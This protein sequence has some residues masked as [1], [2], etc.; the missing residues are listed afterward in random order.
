MVQLHITDDITQG[1][2]GQAL[3][4]ENGTLHAVGIQL[5][6]GHLVE[7]D[8]IDLHGD[9]ILGDH[10]LRRKVH[11]LLLQ[12][13]ALRHTVHQR[14]L[15]VQTGLPGGIVGT[16]SFNDELGRLRDHPDIGHQQKDHQHN[17]NNN[18]PHNISPPF[19]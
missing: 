9:V 12:R 8:G 17:Q 6:I 18:Q 19:L 5:G 1:G 2:S 15:Q 10:R 3:D 13:D 11:H 16:Q 7:H 4:G 14:H